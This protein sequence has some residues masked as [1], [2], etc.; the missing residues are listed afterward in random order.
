MARY[1]R[2]EDDWARQV[3]EHS[4][5]GPYDDYGWERGQSGLPEFRDPDVHLN[6]RE[7]RERRHER[8]Q[9]RME[10]E[11]LSGGRF[12]HESDW[13]QI[14]PFSGMGPRGYRRSDERILEDVCERLTQHGQIDARDIEVKVQNGEVTLSGMVNDRRTKRLAEDVAD[15]VAGVE[16]VHNQ[17]RLNKSGQP[18]GGAGRRDEVGKSGVY[19]AS[20][21]NEAPGDAEARGMASWG[22]GERGAAGYQD[23]GSSELNL[24]P[25]DQ[26]N[27]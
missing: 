15:S 17:L 22:Q 11:R 24:G 23:S 4:W 2:E 16:D 5:E 14:G 26:G 18:G 6:R 25:E 21:I 20:S 27:P 9:E 3:P 8:R 13:N 19:P 7:R 12:Q 10:G 1:R